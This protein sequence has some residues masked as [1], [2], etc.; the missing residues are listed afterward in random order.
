MTTNR[1]P[2]PW[3]APLCLG[4]ALVMLALL[5]RSTRPALQ[6]TQAEIEMDQK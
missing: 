5:Y 4:L 6:K 1:L 2:W 3:V